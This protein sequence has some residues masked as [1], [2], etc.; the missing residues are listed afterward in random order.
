M[1]RIFRLLSFAGVA[2][3][4]VAGAALAQDPPP[5]D[6]GDTATVA[7]LTALAEELLAAPDAPEP[8]ETGD[9]LIEAVLTPDTGGL[10]A[11][12]QRGYLRMAV[13][14][15]PLMIAFDGEAGVGVAMI[16]AQEMEKYLAG[17]PDAGE[18]PT[19]VVPTP[20]PRSVIAERVAEGLSDFTTLTVTRAEENPALTYTRPL[21]RDVN[22]VPVL[23]AEI[24]GVETL[25]DLV[26]I[27]VYVS[28]GSRYEANLRRLNANRAR[29]GKAPL[30]VKFVDARLD[31]YDLIEMVEIGLIPATVATDFKATFWNTVYT[32]V[33]VRTDLE[34]TADG[35]IAW[36]LRA[37]NPE[38]SEAIDGFAEIAKKGTLLGNIVLKRYASSADW[39]ENLGTDDARIRI[40]EV[41]PVIDR[42]A[43]EYAF[44]PELVLAQAYQESRLDQTKTSHVGAIGVMQVMP[45]TAAD[46]VVGIPDVSGLD[47]NVRAGVKYLR[48]LR[49]TFFDDPEIAPLDQTLLSF[50]AYNAGPGGV[51]RARAKARE[52]GLDPNVWFENVEM[53]I[54]QSV[55]R[56]PA[57]YVRNIFKYYVSY[58]LLQELEA[59]AEAARGEIDALPDD[60]SDLPPLDRAAA[61]EDLTGIV[62]GGAGEDMAAAD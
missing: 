30:T 29:D 61:L 51:K 36:A 54:Q 7:G 22:D 32:S 43:R 59:D 26:G 62:V 50:A 39:I 15:D 21:I 2:V 53:A 45:A 19:V 41:G 18:T 8:V 47:D 28:E 35:R 9:V 48:W 16:L 37:D 56:E 13:A 14:P 6:S 46:P 3:A 20:T 27:P 12:R 5:P 11:V 42:Y 31:D 55:S 60:I 17:L 10:E 33:D 38:L 52:M 24:A 57:V 58:R 23:G 34:L 44:E 49:D 25:D 4:T 1:V 40:D